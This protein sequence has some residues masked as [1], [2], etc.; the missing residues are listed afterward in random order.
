MFESYRG[1][2]ACAALPSV[3]DAWTMFLEERRACLCPT[4]I[5]ADY[6]QVSRWL[7]RC[8]VQD[9][10]QGRQVVSWVLHQKPEKSARRVCMF[11]RGM[12]RWASSEDVSLLPRNPVQ[13]FR[14]PKAPQKNGEVTVIPRNEIALVLVAL[15][16]RNPAK[17]E[18]WSLYAEWQLQTAMRTGEV[19]ALRWSDIDGQRVRVHSNFTLTHGLKNSTKTNKERWVP[20]NSRCL[21]I[22]EELPRDNEFLFPW[23]RYTYQ[24]FFRIKVD[25]LYEAGLIKARYR[26]YDLRHV[27]ISRW[28]EN[29]IPV[30]QAAK[31][32]GNTSEVIWNH[33]AG[34]TKEY[35]IPVL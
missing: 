2:A 34:S 32:A 6:R 24:S 28:L 10:T 26:P 1:A 14:M 30:A 25:K 23:N 7:E 19:R 21:E 15:E 3:E 20:L 33:Y 5:I 17:K 16:R 35:E 4:S 29:G 27:A 12:Y 11:V 8:P 22:L 18:N 13:N 9:L 31:W